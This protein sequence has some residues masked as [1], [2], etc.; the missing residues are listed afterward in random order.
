MLDLAGILFSTIMIAI[1]VINALR[2]DSTQAW[3]G[4]LR[5]E[6]RQA[7]SALKRSEKSRLNARPSPKGRPWK[8]SKTL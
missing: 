1:V 7:S 5:G 4:A 8:R 3:F 6:D 2:L